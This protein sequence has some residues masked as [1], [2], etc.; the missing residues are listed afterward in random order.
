M[1]TEQAWDKWM[2]TDEEGFYSGIDPEAPAEIKEA[3]N[4]FMAEQAAAKTKGP[5]AK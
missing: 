5:I 3:Y 4:K 2:L 1:R